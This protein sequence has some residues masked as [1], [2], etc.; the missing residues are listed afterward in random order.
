MPH[1]PTTPFY[2]D[3]DFPFYTSGE[4]RHWIVRQTYA[5]EDERKRI[6]AEIGRRENLRIDDISR[7]NAAQ[8]LRRKS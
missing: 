1:E 3:G 8:G 7:M 6:M 5:S 4:L 2:P